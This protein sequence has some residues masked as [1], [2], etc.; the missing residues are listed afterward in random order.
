MELFNSTDLQ[1][2]KSVRMAQASC[3]SLV[4]IASTLAVSTSVVVSVPP[5][6]AAPAPFPPATW[7]QQIANNIGKTGKITTVQVGWLQGQSN[8]KY[9]TL[10]S[11]L[12][13]I[14][15]LLG[16]NY[17]IDLLVPRFI[18]AGMKFDMIIVVF[19]RKDNVVASY[20]LGLGIYDGP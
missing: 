8:G 12:S 3:L 2:Q 13:R 16:D 19:D 14:D 5:S 6:F 15:K 10:V 1:L 11:F 4:L 20:D 18:K 9:K 17:K 7:I